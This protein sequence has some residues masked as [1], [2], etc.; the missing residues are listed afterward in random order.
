MHISLAAQTLFYIGSFPVTNAIL[1]SWIVTAILIVIGVLVGLNFK[2]IPSTVQQ[3]LEMVYEMIEDLAVSIGGEAGKKY[4]PL[5]VTLFLYILLSNWLG[6]IPGVG[7]IGT[8]IVEHGEKVF[9]PYIRSGTADLNTTLALAL[10]AVVT[11]QVLGIRSSGILGHLKHFK[12]PL[13]IVSEFS[14]LLSFSFRLFGNVF[15]GEVLLGVAAGILTLVIGGEKIWYGIPGGLIQIPFLGLE[16][17][18]GFIQAF[19]FA[20]LTL[21]FIGVFTAGHSEVHSTEEVS[22]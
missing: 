11:A 10:I 6:L 21:V 22:H 8:H 4:A 16:L 5:A 1:T 20:A 12:N 3:L 7:S 14:K 17:L 19:I 18:V 15:A 9:A 13:E 2:K